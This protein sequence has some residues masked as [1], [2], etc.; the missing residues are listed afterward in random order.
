M[1]TQLQFGDTKISDAGLEHLA[2]LAGLK[3]IKVSRSN[4][5]AEGLARLQTAIPGCKI[6][7]KPTVKPA[8]K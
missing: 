5:T 4:V 8:G 6:D 1:L 7:W 3:S 2:A